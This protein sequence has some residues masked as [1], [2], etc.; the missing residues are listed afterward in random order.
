MRAR[1]ETITR[2]IDGGTH[3][4]LT[5]DGHPY[6]DLRMDAFSE[7]GEGTGGPGVV[8]QYEIVYT[9]LEA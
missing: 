4:L 1:I 2:F 7:L 5:A 3:T 9:Q 6:A 8:V